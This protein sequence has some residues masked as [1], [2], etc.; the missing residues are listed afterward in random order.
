MEFLSW[1]QSVCALLRREDL[2][3]SFINLREFYINM[4]L[5]IQNFLLKIFMNIF[6]IFYI[7]YISY[8]ILPTQ[9][10]NHVLYLHCKLYG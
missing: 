4:W 8:I 7:E 9:G 10:D 6:L 5:L 2:Y 3:L 1:L